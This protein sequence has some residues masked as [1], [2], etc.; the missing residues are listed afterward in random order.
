MTFPSITLSLPTWVN[1]L[2]PPPGQVFATPESRMAFAIVLARQN[3]RRGTGGPFGA[4]VFD[5]DNG[6]L[7]APGVNLV[8]S[9]TCSVAHAELVALMTAQ[10]LAGSFSLRAAGR[11]VELTSTTEPCA[12]CLGALP[13]AGIRQ[14]ACGAREADARA[15]GFDEGDKPSGWP[16][17]LEK[18]GIRVMRDVCRPEAVAVLEE[19]RRH[20][21]EIYNGKG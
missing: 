2:L 12:M 9:A 17:L 15:I 3:I 21:G 18:R 14:L 6:T 20:G 16:A 4:A 10:R 13:W 19:Y 5:L 11:N 7:I 1:D 8:T